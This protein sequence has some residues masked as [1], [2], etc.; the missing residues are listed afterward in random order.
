[1]VK[2]APKKTP[3]I[4][5]PIVKP[6]PPDLDALVSRATALRDRAPALRSELDTLLSDLALEGRT[7]DP[8]RL[9][10][11]AARLRDLEQRAK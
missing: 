10:Q 7:R 11:L 9:A 5:P 8:A 2:S 3:P 1:V 6:S 4:A